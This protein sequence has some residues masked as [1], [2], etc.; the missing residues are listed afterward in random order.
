MLLLLAL[1]VVSHASAAEDACSTASKNLEQKKRQL[2]GYFEAL[3]KLHNEQDARL[4][5][6][7]NFKI[8]ELSEQ[9]RNLEAEMAGCPGTNAGEG[10][11]AIKSDEINMLPNHAM[12]FERCFCSF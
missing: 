6:V 9:I 4:L 11:S 8:S 3:K 2:A 12:S 1:T 7:M 10:L 5:E